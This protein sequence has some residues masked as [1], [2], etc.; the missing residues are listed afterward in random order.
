[1]RVKIKSTI[2]VKLWKNLE[3]APLLAKEVHSNLCNTNAESLQ[4]EMDQQDH[5]P[6]NSQRSGANTSVE[7]GHMTNAM[8]GKCTSA[9]R[10]QGKDGLQPTHRAC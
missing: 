2:G 1:M 6:C 8:D 5:G 4:N 7:D 3:R 9:A 10:Q